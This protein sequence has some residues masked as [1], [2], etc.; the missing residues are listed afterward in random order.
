MEQFSQP[1]LYEWRVK[2]GNWPPGWL[3]TWMAEHHLTQV[4]FFAL[5][6]RAD[7][8]VKPRDILRDQAGNINWPVIVYPFVPDALQPELAAL[9]N[10]KANHDA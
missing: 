9:I 5:S 6:T 10:R 1:Q 3:S 7:N 4:L 2:F 8:R